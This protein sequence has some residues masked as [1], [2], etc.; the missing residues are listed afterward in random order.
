MVMGFPG[1]SVVKNL[2]V[3]QEKRIQS[4]CQEDPLEK[5]M[6]THSSILAN[7]IPWIE[8]PAGLQ[9]MASQGVRHSLMNYSSSSNYYGYITLHGKRYCNEVY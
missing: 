6:V 2:P 7:K 1:D 5:E 3:K 8:E 4:L 9:P